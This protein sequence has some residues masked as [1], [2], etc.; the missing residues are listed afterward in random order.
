MSEYIS[1]CMCQASLLSFPPL[2][3][4]FSSSLSTHFS[5]SLSTHFSSSALY[6]DAL[7]VSNS[8]CLFFPLF[9]R[10]FPSC[11]TDSMIRVGGDYQAQIPEFKPGKG[12]RGVNLRRD[13]YKSLN[14]MQFSQSAWAW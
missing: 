14:P 4:H 9:D 13:E 8:A 12:E 6:E 2:S 10:P 5:S 11:E 1:V 3:T 7:P